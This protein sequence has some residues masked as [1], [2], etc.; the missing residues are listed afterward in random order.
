MI[1]VNGQHV[2]LP[3]QCMLVHSTPN[4]DWFSFKPILKMIQRVPGHEHRIIRDPAVEIYIDGLGATLIPPGDFYM[5][6]LELGTHVAQF[7]L[8]QDPIWNTPSVG[9]EWEISCV[10]EPLSEGVS[11]RS[12]IAARFILLPEKTQEAT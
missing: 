2:P 10:A 8:P 5:V 6:K 4:N 7:H 9:A 1:L 12:T 11:V 3:D